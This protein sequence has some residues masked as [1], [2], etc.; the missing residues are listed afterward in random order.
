[1]THMFLT[2]VHKRGTELQVVVPKSRSGKVYHET[3]ARR[4]LCRK[5]AARGRGCN[6]SRHCRKADHRNAT[7][8]N[9]LVRDKTRPLGSQFGTDTL[10]PSSWL[11]SRHHLH[12][13]RQPGGF[14]E[15]AKF[16]GRLELRN[17]IEF[18]ER[19]G[20]RIGQAPHRSGLKSP[21][22]WGVK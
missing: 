11:I 10:S 6:I 18:L 16:R 3:D 14:L 20:E 19:R 21:R 9:H 15:G 8:A 13:R 22:A 5:L 12:S 7:A 4:G 1:M 17:R 2:Y